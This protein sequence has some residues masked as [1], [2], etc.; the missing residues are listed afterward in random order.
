MSNRLN[1]WGLLVLR[2]G[3]G[4]VFLAHGLQKAFVLGPDGVAGFFGAVGIPFPYLNAVFITG[5]EI[6]G[7][8]ALVS[9][10]LTR[11]FAPLLAA[12]MVVAI[13]TVHLPNG[14]F[15]ASNGYEF[16]LTLLLAN[17]GLTLTG[18]GAYAVDARLF[19]RRPARTDTAERLR[20]AA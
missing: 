4:V 19:G 20:A 13:A 2:I 8:L 1:D 16:A 12:T 5:L 10:A 15:M 14:F 6:V 3:V 18:A 7:G 9:G 11:V 17:T